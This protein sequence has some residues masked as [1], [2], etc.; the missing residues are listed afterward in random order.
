[1]RKPSTIKRVTV[2][3]ALALSLI[4][5]VTVGSEKALATAGYLSAPTGLSLTSYAGASSFVVNN[6]TTIYYTPNSTYGNTIPSASSVASFLGIP[7]SSISS[8]TDQTTPYYSISGSN[9][10]L[11]LSLLNQISSTF[12]T[13][14]AGTTPVASGTYISNVFM[15]DSGSTM[16]GAQAG[17]LVF[18]Y[19]FYQSTVSSSNGGISGATIGPFNDPN[20][21]VYTLGTGSTDTSSI[22]GTTISCSN[23]TELGSLTGLNGVLDPL[24][25]LAGV[26]G[27]VNFSTGGSI[28]TLGL[29]N[30]TGGI[31]AGVY[32]PEILVASNAT[33]YSLG[34]LSFLGLGAGSVPVFVP[35]V[36]EPGTLVL[37]G[38]ALGLVAFIAVKRRRNQ[39]VA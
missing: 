25:T 36:P 7:V 11:N 28:L 31:A 2:A 13:T 29:S 30:N 39:M 24:D 32:T 15:I 21:F 19:Q 18:T 33:S 9:G 12:T 6:S 8:L 14:L 37:F 5:S 17:D 10:T 3:T 16:S 23:C 35:N 34:G 27:N 26:Q 4:T 22:G 20:N 1:M 38:T